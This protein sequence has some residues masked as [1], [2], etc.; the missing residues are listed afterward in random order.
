MVPLELIAPITTTSL[1]V[2]R[3]IGPFGSNG[4]LFGGYPFFGALKLKPKGTPFLDFS[5]WRLGQSDVPSSLEGSHYK[6]EPKPSATQRQGL[7]VGQGIRFG[8]LVNGTKD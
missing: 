1:R 8:T 6:R 3:G 5:T 7:A 4:C 2:P